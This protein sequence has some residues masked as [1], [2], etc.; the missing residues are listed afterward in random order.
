MHGTRGNAELYL[1]DV[2]AIGPH[3]A[4]QATSDTPISPLGSNTDR[5]RPPVKRLIKIKAV[6]ERIPV[7]RSQLYIMIAAGKLPK[8]IHLCGGQG[9]FWVES[10]I[11]EW[12]QGQ[13]DAERNAA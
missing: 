10:E 1:S 13:I 4:P 8:P 7:S 9:A 11:D 2:A 12:I 6:L 3:F 5:S